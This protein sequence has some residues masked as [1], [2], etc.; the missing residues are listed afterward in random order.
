[1]ITPAALNDYLDGLLN[2]K[3]FKDYAPNGLQ[4]EGRDK[5]YRLCTAVTASLNIIKQ[6]CALQADALLV[7]HGYFWRGEASNITGIKYQRIA[8][9]IK[10]NMNL[11][12][13]HLPLDTHKT[14]GNN[15]QIAQALHLDSV[16]AKNI[17]QTPNLLWLGKPAEAW[18]LPECEERLAHIFKQK[19]QMIK[20]HKRPITT[21]A[22]CSGGAQDFITQAADY[23]AD[24]YISG[25][26]SERTYHLAQELGVH[27]AAC[28]HHATER[29]GVRALGAHLAA[30]FDLEHHFLDEPNPV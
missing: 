7:H 2:A 12:A 5:I 11:F 19:P 9:L 25:E 18:T 4:I 17:N 3:E 23:Q 26:I 16:V 22:W 27:Y 29:F 20:A 21:L 15:A 6:A 24:L 8:Q 28:G 13:Y 10:A 14:F 1:M 30:H